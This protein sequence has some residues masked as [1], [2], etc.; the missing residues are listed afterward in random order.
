MGYC[1]FVICK[2]FEEDLGCVYW[3]VVLFFEDEQD[4]VEDE[5]DDC[6]GVDVGCVGFGKY[7]F[8]N[9]FVY[10]KEYDCLYDDKSENCQ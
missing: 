4:D 10:V 9:C 6:C 7:D 1:D 2:Q 5:V 8:L 3:Y